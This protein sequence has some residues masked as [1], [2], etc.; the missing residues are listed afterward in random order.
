MNFRYILL[1]VLL[2]IFTFSSCKTQKSAAKVID[3]TQSLL[4]KI[5]KKGI[6]TSYLFGT[7]HVLPK[8]DF[9]LKSKVRKAFDESDLLVLELDMDNPSMMMEMMKYAML[10]GDLTLDQIFSEEDYKR[11]DAELQATA[12]M[13]M[14]LFNK[15]KPMFVEQMLVSKYVGQEPASFEMSFV[16]MAAKS[17]KEIEGLE[18][19][20]FQMGMMDSVPYEEQAEQIMEMI[21]EEEKSIGMFDKLLETYKSENPDA[22]YKMF[23]TLYEMEEDDLDLMLHNRNKDWIAKIGDFAKKQKVFFAVGAGHLGGKEGVLNLLRE[24]GY[25]V[26][27]IIE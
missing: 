8:K 27:P 18:D 10:P 17:K 5:E 7:I 19:V 24:D 13:S 9:V 23:S 3:D 12:G 1:S 11:L 20:A 22:L 2:L 14:K 26:S 4:Y 25:I 16:E 6:K 21:D 15:M